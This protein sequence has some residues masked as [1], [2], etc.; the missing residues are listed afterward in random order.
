MV[1]PRESE[2]LL[3]IRRVPATFRFMTTQSDQRTEI[4][5]TQEQAARRAGVSLATWRRWERDPTSVT[6][7]VRAQC[8][9]A[10]DEAEDGQWDDLTAI[11]K[12]TFS[13]DPAT[14][15]RRQAELQEAYQ[16]LAQMSY[17]MFP[18][19]PKQPSVLVRKRFGQAVIRVRMC[20]ALA[21]GKSEM[22]AATSVVALLNEA[23]IP[24]EAP[25]T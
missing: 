6:E 2:A 1:T 16:H 5:L 12:I 11:L 15:E 17:E 19:G 10:L 7:D 25:A 3:T 18:A 23:G 24:F 20:E 22:E 9:G 21:A 4:G 14:P 13:T 8:Q